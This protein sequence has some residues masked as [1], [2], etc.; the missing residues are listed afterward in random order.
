VTVDSIAHVNYMANTGPTRG[1]CPIEI[2]LIIDKPVYRVRDVATLLGCSSQWVTRLLRQKRISAFRPLG[3][4][5]RIPRSEMRRLQKEGV[6]PPPR[7]AP[8]EKRAYRVRE[9]AAMFGCS[10]RWIT[11]LICQGRIQAGKPSGGHWRI[12]PD[13]V[14]RLQKDGLPR[15]K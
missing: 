1:N 5:W 15:Y 9:V 11:K 4:H 7:K 6:L 10:S 12:W 14:E 2:G 13:E 3:G 8:V